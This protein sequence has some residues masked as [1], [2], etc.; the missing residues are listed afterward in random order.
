MTCYELRGKQMNGEKAHLKY[1]YYW[2][3]FSF[4]LINYDDYKVAI[5]GEFGEGI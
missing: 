4:K 3:L 1:V 5:L 2:A